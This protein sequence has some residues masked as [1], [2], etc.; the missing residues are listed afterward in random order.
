MFRFNLKKRNAARSQQ[1]AKAVM[2]TSKITYIKA[3]PLFRI[4]NTKT[5]LGDETSL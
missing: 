5:S 1:M 4:A 3:P 2:D